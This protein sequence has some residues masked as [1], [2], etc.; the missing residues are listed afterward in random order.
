MLTGK[1]KWEL[2]R[3]FYLGGCYLRKRTWSMEDLSRLVYL[4]NKELGEESTGLIGVEQDPTRW[5]VHYLNYKGKKGI[6]YRRYMGADWKVAW[7]LLQYVRYHK[8][9]KT[10]LNYCSGIIPDINHPMYDE[11]PEEKASREPQWYDDY[12]ISPEEKAEIKA[13]Y[14]DLDRRNAEATEK[15]MKMFALGIGQKYEDVWG[16]QN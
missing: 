4:I 5:W 14:E 10:P 12:E 15:R 16:V 11:T 6:T 7:F 1:E 13:F 2:H 8:N 3:Y 9:R